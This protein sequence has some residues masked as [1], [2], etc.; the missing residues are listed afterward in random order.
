MEKEGR[1]TLPCF[2]YLYPISKRMRKRGGECTWETGCG[3]GGE[4]PG[5]SDATAKSAVTLAEVNLG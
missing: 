5:T 4:P 1:I 2:D 3:D